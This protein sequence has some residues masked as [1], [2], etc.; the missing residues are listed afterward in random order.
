MRIWDLYQHSLDDRPVK[1]W[2][3]RAFHDGVQITESR[4]TLRGK[5][6]FVATVD[7]ARAV[8]KRLHKSKESW[9]DVFIYRIAVRDDQH[10]SWAGYCVDV[11]E[12]GPTVWHQRKPRMEVGGSGRRK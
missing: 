7:D 1:R 5:D 6:P 2:I 4:H 10:D 8:L 11:R 3:W 12:S 9:Q